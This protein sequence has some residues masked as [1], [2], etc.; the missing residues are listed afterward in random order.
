[1][2]RIAYAGEQIP[3]DV[4]VN[5]PEHTSSTVEIAAEG[6]SLGRTAAELEKGLNHL[7]VHARVKASGV[8]SISGSIGET[9]FEQ[10]VE[11]RR[12]RVLYLSQDPAGTE[13][14]LLQ[15]F[16]EA[17]FDVVRDPTLLDSDLT[18]VQLVVLNNLDLNGLSL[19]A[20]SAWRAIPKMAAVCCSSEASAS[21]TKTTR[22]WMC[23]IKPCL[24][25][26]PRR[27]R[28][29]APPWC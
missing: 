1:M 2:P 5:A 27:R 16:S 11:L 25:S 26:S 17:D 18:A 12:A 22:R 13:T 8:T 15:V 14:N 19:R 23:S 7:R 24:Q 6:K 4:T 10:A 28:R 9:R 3:I 29:R 21:S 20:R